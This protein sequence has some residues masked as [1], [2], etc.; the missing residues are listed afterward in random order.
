[1]REYNAAQGQRQFEYAAGHP[2]FG[3][4]RNF[5]ACAQ[6]YDNLWRQAVKAKILS[7]TAPLNR[8]DVDSLFVTNRGAAWPGG[9][10][11]V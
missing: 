3:N 11:G 6:Y 1:M 5:A 8:A 10:S 2:L 7:V 9:P 4:Q